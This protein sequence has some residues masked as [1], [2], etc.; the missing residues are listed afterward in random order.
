MSGRRRR[1]AV[2]KGTG[3][4][5]KYNRAGNFGSRLSPPF[6]APES[7]NGVG[8][9]SASDNEAS[10]ATAFL[11]SASPAPAR[12]SGPISDPSIGERAALEVASRVQLERIA[13]QT[14]RSL[15]LRLVASYDV[16]GVVLPV[17]TSNRNGA[18]LATTVARASAGP[19]AALMGVQHVLKTMSAAPLG[20]VAVAVQATMA[21]TT[22][23]T[24]D[25]IASEASWMLYTLGVCSNESLSV[26][27]S[28]PDMCAM[29]SASK[30]QGNMPTSLTPACVPML[31]GRLTLLL[32]MMMRKRKIRL[33]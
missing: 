9:S 8:G 6:P 16:G 25:R 24:A 17:N 3:V 1:I 32:L 28:T 5:A 14:G 19:V 7:D 27:L 15:P 11:V 18:R 30:A 21:L 33:Q 26:S 13:A 20:A 31:S 29:Q 2:R 4:L 12:P 23:W 10:E 22:S